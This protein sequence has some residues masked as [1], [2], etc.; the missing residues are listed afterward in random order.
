MEEIGDN[1]GAGNLCVL[2]SRIVSRYSASLADYIDGMGIIGDGLQTLKNRLIRY[3]EN[4][5]R[6]KKAPLRRKLLGDEIEYGG[7]EDAERVDCEMES[8][9]L[10]SKQKAAPS[11]LSKENYG[12]SNWQPSDFPL[13]ETDD[14]QE[15]KRLW[16][17]TEY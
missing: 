6:K 5:R 7:N 1:P 2:A 4:E 8:S 11:S 15:S 14:T 9:R 17:M 3:V 16:L 10:T 13:G 12:C